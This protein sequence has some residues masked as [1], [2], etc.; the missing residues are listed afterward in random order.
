MYKN[1][2]EEMPAGLPGQ[3]SRYN[4][5]ENIMPFIVEDDDCQAG[6]FAF[7]GSEPGK[8]VVAIA[9]AD[10]KPIGIIM[11]TPFRTNTGAKSLNH[12]LSGTD[13]SVVN[14]C[15]IYVVPKNEP[16]YKDNVYVD[17]T[18]GHIKTGKTVPTP[19]EGEGTFVDTGFRVSAPYEIN[20]VAEITDKNF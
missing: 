8:N 2:I 11:R 17:P 7:D 3:L 14:D 12:Y 13:I 19:E 4:G 9:K 18:T 6:V 5:S 10:V 16:K 1:V 15:Y 20:C